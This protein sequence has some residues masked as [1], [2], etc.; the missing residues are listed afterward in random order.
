MAKL[1]F[2]KIKKKLFSTYFWVCLSLGL[3]SFKLNL[4]FGSFNELDDAEISML[5]FLK[6]RRPKMIEF[7]FGR[8]RNVSSKLKKKIRNSFKLEFALK[9]VFRGDFYMCILALNHYLNFPSS[10]FH[11]LSEI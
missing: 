2:S 7:I 5:S 8:T 10:T 4:K 6:K 3:I 11:K 9:L 1:F